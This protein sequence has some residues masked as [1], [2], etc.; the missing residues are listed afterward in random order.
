MRSIEDDSSSNPSIFELF[1]Q[2]TMDV[3]EDVQS[4]R[5]HR[6]I[7]TDS[8]IND[9]ADDDSKQSLIKTVDSL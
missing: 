4:I 5:K 3:S 8:I 1:D 9:T 7:T 6:D 2:R